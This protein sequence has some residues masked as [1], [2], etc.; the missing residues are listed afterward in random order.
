VTQ[1]DLEEQFRLATRIRDAQAEIYESITL[2]RGVRTQAKEA[3][4]RAQEAGFG[5]DL[6]ERA[7]TIE[8]KL[9]KIERDLINAK[10][11][12]NQ[13]PIN[14]PPMLD[15]QMGYLYRQVVRAYS[16]PTKASYDRFEELLL[17]VRDQGARVRIVLD[18]DVAELN[19]MLLDRGV[20]GDMVKPSK[21]RLTGG[22]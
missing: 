17:Q 8:S 10:S 9:T 15:N 2:L 20:P 1:D 16:R 12:S 14:F 13:D 4:T 21:I 3:A 6:L 11:E 7:D 18:T 19:R 5:E 22:L